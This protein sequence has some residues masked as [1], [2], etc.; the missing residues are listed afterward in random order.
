MRVIPSSGYYTHFV[1]KQAFQAE[2]GIIKRLSDLA[3]ELLQPLNIPQPGIPGVM[4][5]S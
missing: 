5:V 1:S 4:N 2:L 3:D